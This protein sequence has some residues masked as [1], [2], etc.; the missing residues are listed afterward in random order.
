MGLGDD[1]RNL[2][3]Q[4]LKAVFFCTVQ[5]FEAKEILSGISL[6]NYTALLKC[7]GVSDEAGSQC[8]E[9]IKG[10]WMLDT[11]LDP[12]DCVVVEVRTWGWYM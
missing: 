3:C 4:P 8:S 10:R 7:I 11:K 5:I 1:T 2:R 6:G 9:V 12:K